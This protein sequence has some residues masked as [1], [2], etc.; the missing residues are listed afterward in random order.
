MTISGDRHHRGRMAFHAGVAAELR[1][2]QDY[3]RRG[4]AIARRRWRGA[5]G[6]IDLIVRDGNGLIFVEVKKSRSLARAAESLSLRQMQRIYASAE[7]FL[8]TEPRG[9][10]TDVRFDVALVDGSGDLQIIENAFGHG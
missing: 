1:I 7:E 8:G 4:F 9:S 6:E 3:E 10:L 2:A 5:G